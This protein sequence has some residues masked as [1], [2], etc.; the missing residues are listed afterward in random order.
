MDKK[1]NHVPAI[2]NTIGNAIEKMNVIT[3]DYNGYRRRVE[4]YHYGILGGKKQLHGYQVSNGSKSGEP[5]GWKNFTCLSG[6]HI[7]SIS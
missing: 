4:P 1:M 2:E 6:C 3:F 5:I 7:I